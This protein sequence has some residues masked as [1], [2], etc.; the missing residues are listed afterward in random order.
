MAGGGKFVEL[1][2]LCQSISKFK[3]LIH[4]IRL[5]LSITIAYIVS[6]STRIKSYRAFAV[7]KAVLTFKS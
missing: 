2:S 7:V 3:T 4:D 6:L 1:C 5:S